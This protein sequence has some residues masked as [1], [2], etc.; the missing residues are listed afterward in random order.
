MARF[1]PAMKNAF[2]AARRQHTAVAEGTSG[3]FAG[4]PTNLV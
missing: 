3:C 1:V 4:L 2:A